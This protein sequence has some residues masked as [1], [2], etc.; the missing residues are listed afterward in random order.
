MT[1]K[2]CG[3]C[4]YKVAVQEKYCPNC[5]FKDPWK[6]VRKWE[7]SKYDEERVESIRKEGNLFKILSLIFSGSFILSSL[8][9][10]VFTHL[11]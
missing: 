1:Y 6:I 2:Q 9:F 11:F 4:N 10:I 7:L 5:G 8:L 3:F